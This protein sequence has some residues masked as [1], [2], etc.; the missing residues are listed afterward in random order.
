MSKWVGVATVFLF[1]NSFANASATSDY[2][3]QSN[4]K[5]RHAAAAE[6]VR[7]FSEFENAIP[8]LTPTEQQWVDTERQKRDQE[9]LTGSAIDSFINSREYQLSELHKSIKSIRKLVAMIQDSQ[10]KNDVRHE[11]LYWVSL[12][13]QFSQQNDVG[14]TLESLQA[15]RVIRKSD[16]PRRLGVNWLIGSADGQVQMEWAWWARAIWDGFLLS[17]SSQV[18]FK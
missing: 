12:L 9:Q 15:H 13:Y 7:I 18:A 11:T 2:G 10:K 5:D 8:D 4:W 16:F 17:L 1:I 6:Y 14:Q 3:M